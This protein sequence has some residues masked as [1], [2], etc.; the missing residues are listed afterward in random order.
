[1]VQIP[2]EDR[3]VVGGQASSELKIA[4]IGALDWWFAPW[5]ELFSVWVWIGLDWFGFESR[6]TL[7]VWT[8]TALVVKRSSSDF[9]QASPL[10]KQLF[11]TY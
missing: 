10:I 11:Y 8:W 2:G 7:F 1:M 6:F 9:F 3:S 5:F 4:P